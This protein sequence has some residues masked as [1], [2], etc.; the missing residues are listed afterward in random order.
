[1][2]QFEANMKM[3]RKVDSVH[4]A[5]RQYYAVQV[6]NAGRSESM[7]NMGR[8]YFDGMKGLK[9]D[10]AEGLKWLHRAMEAGSGNAAFTLGYCNL[11]GEKDENK[12]INVGKKQQSSVSFEPA[13]QLLIS[14][15]KGRN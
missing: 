9:Q 5:A 12:A 7:F 13:S 10:K 8:Y 14:N 1:M 15:E 3:S 2:S 4:F 6:C 11:N